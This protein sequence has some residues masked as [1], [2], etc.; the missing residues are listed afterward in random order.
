MR[1]RLLRAGALILLLVPQALPGGLPPPRA[2]AACVDPT[3]R[4]ASG[5]GHA[6]PLTVRNWLP[7][8]RRGEPVSSGVPLPPGVASS[9][10]ELRL[11]DRSMLEVPAQFRELARWS[12]GSLRWVLV[13]LQADVDARGESTYYLQV[14]TRPDEVDTPLRVEDLGYALLVHTGPL[15]FEVR[16][17]GPPLLGPFYLDLDGDGSPEERVAIEGDVVV[18]GEDGMEYLAGLGDRAVEVEEAGPLRV[19]ILVRG[20][21]ASPTGDALLNYTLRIHAFA[22]RS[23]LRV[24]Y[25]EENVLPCLNDGSGQPNCLRLGSPNSVPFR[26]VELRLNLTRG[27]GP[28]YAI[29][30]DGRILRGDLT[31]AA[32][33]YQD[34]SG[35]PDW[36]RWPG[37]SFRGYLV[38]VDGRELHRGDRS[39][40]WADLSF[41]GFGLTV[42]KRY[43]WE[44]YP[45]S[46][47]LVSSG[48][49]R[50]GLMPTQ[51]SAPFEHRAGERKTHE[52]VL[53]F[54]S[55]RFE[56][57]HAREVVGLMD[58][59][60]ARAPAELYL[61]YGLYERWPPYSPLDPWLRHYELNNLAAV[62]G[63][64]GPYA[65]NLFDARESVD[66]Y[67]WMH[68]GDVRVVDEDGGTGQSNLQYDFEY[69]MLVQSLRLLGRDDLNSRRW[70]LLG[71]QAAR[72]TADIDVLHVHWGDPSQP[73][74]YW[75]RW[76]WGGMFWHTPHGESGLENPHRGSSPSL[77]FQFARGLFLYY[78]LTGYRP[79]WEAATEVADNTY[80][81]VINGPGEPGYSGTTSDEARAPANALEILLAAYQATWSGKFLEA[82]RKVVEESHFDRKWYRDGLAPEYEG[83]SVAPWQQAMLM[84]ALGKYLDLVRELTGEVDE[85]ARSSLLGYADWMLRYA[86]HA[87]GDSAFSGPHFV[88]RWWGDGRVGDWSPGG[89]ANAWMLVISDAFAYAWEYSGNQTYLRV[90]LQQFL[91]GS[92]YFWY[93]G[94]PVGQ[95]ATGKQ[96]AILSTSGFMASLLLAWLWDAWKISA[97]GPTGGPG[98][99]IG[100]RAGGVLPV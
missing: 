70:W 3:S 95:F 35:G 80:W 29:P 83:R 38:R 53:L 68:F 63:T 92:R 75:I 28:A 55:G 61:D 32:L 9:V 79:A 26:G 37:V 58:P 2:G 31:G 15:S 56:E 47:E 86:Y 96:H 24:Y 22:W 98:K 12:D 77:E 48:Q 39:E 6:I 99:E 64:A 84:V 13:D 67:G 50:V 81:R 82:A 44:S 42:G 69:G 45:S 40:G 71:E 94:N 91:Y 16:R 65:A 23:Y 27:A 97:W 89:G 14:G 51:F 21:H 93:E 19:S 7:W 25:T 36:D 46:I 8:D 88:Y 18:V 85:A 41:E 17:S 66:F 72:H 43:F 62:N 57:E 59:M 87:S 4:R 100:L 49:V 74:S 10:S 54:H 90:A 5:P 11:L 76:C 78:Y 33:L 52:L 30:A 1:S 20:S 60:Q 34:S 73:S